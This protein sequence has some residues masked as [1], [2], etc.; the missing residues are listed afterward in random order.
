VCDGLRQRQPENQNGAATARCPIRRNT[1][2][3]EH[4]LIGKTH[5]GG[6]LTRHRLRVWQ[7]FQAA[8]E[9]MAKKQRQPE[10]D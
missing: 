10:N 5:I 7:W 1:Q 6:Q 8:S 3:I 4:G 2:A 9:Q